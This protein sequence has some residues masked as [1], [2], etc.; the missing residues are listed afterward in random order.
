MHREQGNTGQARHCLRKAIKAD[1]QDVGLKFDYA[2]LYIEVGEYQEGW[3]SLEEIVKNFPNDYESLIKVSKVCLQISL[4]P[5][6]LFHS[7]L[8]ETFFLFINPRLLE[9][10]SSENSEVKY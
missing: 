5:S 9:L 10:C 6:Y 8:C 4:F 3:K 2:L 7:S 1:P